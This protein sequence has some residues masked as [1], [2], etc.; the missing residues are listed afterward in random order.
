MSIS[1]L[2]LQLLDAQHFGRQD[3]LI[4]YVF[5]RSQRIEWIETT[6]IF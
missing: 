3:A 4:D 5:V 1:Q 2:I 6:A